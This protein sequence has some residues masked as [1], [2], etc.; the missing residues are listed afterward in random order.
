LVIGFGIAPPPKAVSGFPASILCK[1]LI[2]ELKKYPPPRLAFPIGPWHDF[3]NPPT[4]PGLDLAAG[5]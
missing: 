1:K 4:R 5:A 2:N 3:P